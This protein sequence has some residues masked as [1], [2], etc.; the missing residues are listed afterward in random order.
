MK[1]FY[2]YFAR[3]KQTPQLQDHVSPRCSHKNNKL[4]SEWESL[5]IE[6]LWRA[7]PADGVFAELSENLFSF[8]HI[9]HVLNCF[10]DLA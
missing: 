5:D 7:F 2:V 8:I 4:A 1:F 10:L 6:P 9:L 3:N